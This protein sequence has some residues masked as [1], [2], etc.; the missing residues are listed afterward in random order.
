MEELTRPK[1]IRRPHWR[2]VVGKCWWLL[3]VRHSRRVL[4]VDIR[5]VVNVIDRFWRVRRSLAFGDR[6][7]HHTARTSTCIRNRR[8]RVLLS[9]LVG[10][11]CTYDRTVFALSLPCRTPHLLLARLL[12]RHSRDRSRIRRGV[13]PRIPASKL[14]NIHPGIPTRGRRLSV[15]PNTVRTVPHA[16]AP[17]PLAS[18]TALVRC[19]VLVDWNDLVSLVG[20][21]RHVLPVHRVV[22]V[23]GRLLLLLSCGACRRDIRI[24]R[25]RGMLVSIRRP[26]LALHGRGTKCEAG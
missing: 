1:W 4:M 26:R 17:L 22:R 24:V 16:L 18:F 5:L 10:P 8:R 20:H 7:A 21:E 14:R 11:A 2:W 9:I 15:P 23:W 6:R 12:W 3:V 19:L 13:R 25:L